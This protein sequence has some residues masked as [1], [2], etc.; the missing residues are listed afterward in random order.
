MTN[1]G[2]NLSSAPGAVIDQVTTVTYKAKIDAL[3]E[4]GAYT[5]T[6]IYSLTGAF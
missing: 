1:G 3:Q 2:A 6:V 5:D 4:T